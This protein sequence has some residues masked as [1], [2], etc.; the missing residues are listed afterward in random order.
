MET[1]PLV[2][3]H[4]FDE[5]MLN[6]LSSLRNIRLCL[7]E[8]QLADAHKTLSDLKDR[9]I[10]SQEEVSTQK[11]TTELVQK[12]RMLRDRNKNPG[13]VYVDELEFYLSMFGD[14]Q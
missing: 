8:K 11:I 12:I 9:G 1:A 13:S 4:E 2:M 3:E 6:E 7:A 5:E 10:T 14:E